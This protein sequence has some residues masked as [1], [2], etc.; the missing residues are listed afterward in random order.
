MGTTPIPC[1]L[2]VDDGLY[3][4]E[5]FAVLRDMGHTVLRFSDPAVEWQKADLIL[6]PTCWRILPEHLK[7]LPLAI[8]EARARAKAARPK[9]SSTKKVKE[10]SHT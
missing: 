9:K 6:G 4:Q 2:V 1:Y 7:F 8:K 3:E 10:A 5:E